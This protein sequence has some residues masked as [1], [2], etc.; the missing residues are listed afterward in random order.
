MSGARVTSVAS[1]TIVAAAMAVIAAGLIQDTPPL[2]WSRDELLAAAIWSAGPGAVLALLAR[3]RWWPAAACLLLIAGLA[4]SFGPAAFAAGSL[5][6]LA[7]LALGRTFLPRDPDRPLESALLAAVL[8][9]GLIATTISWTARAPIH[10]DFVY[11]IGLV[12]IVV[13]RR[14][15]CLQFLE[16][17]RVLVAS[18]HEA[19]DRTFNRLVGALLIALFLYAAGSGAIPETGPDAMTSHYAL[20]HKLQAHGSWSYDPTEVR[21]TLMPKLAVWAHAPFFV[22]GGEMA[23]RAVNLLALAAIGGLVAARLTPAV[24]RWTSGLLVA[25][26][27][28]MPLTIWM[29]TMLSEDPVSTLFFTAAIVAF[30]RLWDRV[31]ETRWLYAGLALLGL[32]VAAKAQLLFG[33]GL[34]LAFVATYLAR[35]PSLDSAVAVA[36]ASLIFFVMAAFPY[37]HAFGLTGSPFYPIDPGAA[38][39]PRWSGKLAWTL[40]YGF[41]FQTNAYLESFPGAVGFFP[42]LG[43]AVFICAAV[44]ARQMAV[45]ILCAV[46]VVFVAALLVQSQYVRY[47]YYVVPAMILCAGLFLS[48]APDIARWAIMAALAVLIVSNVALM[49]SALA[50]SLSLQALVWPERAASVP[51]ERRLYAAINATEEPVRVLVAGQSG[52]IAGLDGRADA[53]G[54]YGEPLLADR[55]NMTRSI[56]EFLALAKEAGVTHVSA[57]GGFASPLIERICRRVCEPALQIGDFSDQ[58]FRLRYPRDPPDLIFGVKFGPTTDLASPMEQRF[59]VKGWSNDRYPGARSNATSA[60]LSLP[61]SVN[62]QWI[63]TVILELS[64]INAAAWRSDGPARFAISIDGET[65]DVADVRAPASTYLSAHFGGEMQSARMLRVLPAP[66]A[67]IGDM[68]IVISLDAA[69]A[70]DASPRRNGDEQVAFLLTYVILEA[71]PDP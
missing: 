30:L 3:S 44:F 6:I 55:L 33:G 19:T 47:I 1:V 46:L 35:R 22:L 15:V 69:G 63:D 71:E 49:R 36:G 8:G 11:V 41:A 56:D 26:F 45:R 52:F 51:G 29:A 14:N 34:G 7:S 66:I 32:A 17:F 42:V 70:G 24:P 37:L 38:V 62:G 4:I 2:N 64:M 16:D 25:T 68:K 39:D 5:T 54:W 61:R 53:G 59:L 9:L 50:P 57:L 20:L 21:F 65:V 48:R 67:G 18:P 43:L 13:A 10:F 27:L 40:P 23:M 60:E 12:A 58:F 28:S 31:D